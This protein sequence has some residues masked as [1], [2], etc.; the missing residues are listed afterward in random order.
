[1]RY[2]WLLVVHKGV[3]FMNSPLGTPV[4]PFLLSRYVRA[5]KN[6]FSSLQV[7]QAQ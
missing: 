1:V 7:L 4:H 2:K 3:T 6:I 5:L